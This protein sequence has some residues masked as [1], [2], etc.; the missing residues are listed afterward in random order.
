[1]TIF[2]KIDFP[3]TDELKPFMLGSNR[4][5]SKNKGLPAS[6]KQQYFLYCKFFSYLALL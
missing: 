5:A 4:I 1:L 6:K 2:D 3:S